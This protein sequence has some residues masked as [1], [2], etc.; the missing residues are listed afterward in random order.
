MPRKIEFKVGLFITLTTLLILISIGYVAY[1]KDAFTKVYTYT[2]LSKSGENL[3]E[4]MP[5]VFWGFTIGRVSS[6][7]LSDNGVLI[8]IRI[9]ERNNRVIR[10]GSTFVLDKPLL[11]ASRIV[12]ST[13]DLNGASLSPDAVPE[14]A[15]SSDIN[16]LIRRMRPIAEKVDRIAANVE[17]LTA[18]LAAPEGEVNRILRNAETLTAGLAKRDSL[19]EMATGDRESVESVRKTLEK[20]R[21]ITL[22][23]EGILKKDSLLEMA[24]GKPESAESIQEILEKVRDIAAQVEGIVKKADAM[25]GKTDGQIYGRDGVLPLVRDILHDLLEKLK[26]IDIT[27]ENINKVSGEA[28]DSTK[29][30]KALRSDLDAG[31]RAI[32]DL[33]DDLDRMIPFKAKPEIK[34]P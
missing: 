7:E 10:T 12:V 33:A 18:K 14:I 21:D 20:M 1:K 22:R 19:L 27:L 16:E 23:V 11:G 25:A 24:T 29:D 30:L 8:R 9:P 26:K 17:R 2:L 5:V 4:G 15:A 13:D 28:A 6:L 34:L 3:T 32:G 31:V